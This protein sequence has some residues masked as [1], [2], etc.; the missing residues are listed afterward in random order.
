M[1]EQTIVWREDF[2]NICLTEGLV[3]KW[4]THQTIIASSKMALVQS[5]GNY[6]LGRFVLH[7]GEIVFR[8]ENGVK[9]CVELIQE[10][11]FLE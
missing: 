7:D 2:D 9:L 4:Y 6:E 1:R 3:E 10:Y 8:L 5:R 11:A